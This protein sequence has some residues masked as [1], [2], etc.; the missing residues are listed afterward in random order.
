[1][2][3]V[4]LFVIDSMKQR[5]S[6]MSS[7]TTTQGLPRLNEPA[8]DFD[9]PTTHGRKTL[10]DFRGKWLVLFSHPAD[11]TPV[12]TTEFIGFAKLQDQFDAIDTQ[13]L[14]LSIDSTHSHIAWTR[15]IKQNF[16]T[17]IGFPIIADLSMKVAHDYGMIMPGA[18]DTAAVRATFVIDPEGI[19]RAML[20][21]PMNAGRAVAEIH[22]LVVALQTAD[23][24]SCAM[25]EGW[26]PGQPVIVP[27]PKTP[28]EAEARAGEGYN[29][30]DW[31]FSTRSL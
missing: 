3:A 19:L 22:R 5:A 6:Q 8:P 18:S 23:A 12:C 15:N 7:T 27:A 26:V 1:M 25:P 20:Y 13:L 29:T 14:G 31:Y 21:Y 16:G 11:F 17:D 30:V 2:G 24:N 28:E 10:A 4:Y 9:A